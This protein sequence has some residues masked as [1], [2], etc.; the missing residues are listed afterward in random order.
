MR[1]MPCAACALSKA[2]LPVNYSDD[3]FQDALSS[4]WCMTASHQGL[5][6]RHERGLAV[7]LPT[8]DFPGL[9]GILV[10]ALICKARRINTHGVAGWQVLQGSRTGRE[11]SFQWK[12]MIGRG[13]K[14]SF[15][16]GNLFVHLLHPRNGARRWREGFVCRAWSQRCRADLGCHGF[17]WFQPSYQWNACQQWG[18]PSP[19]PTSCVSEWSNT[20]I[21]WRSMG[22]QIAIGKWYAP[23]KDR[24][25]GIC[26]APQLLR[27]QT[28]VCSTF[29]VVFT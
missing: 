27:K 11:P 26:K 28:H 12:L 3:Y 9:Q 23:N 15:L 1:R 4:P 21:S 25:P 19:E 8:V 6:P 14:T 29:G 7:C 22:R 2:R 5:H 24:T 20:L 13:G 17:H 10:G 18:Q 16:L